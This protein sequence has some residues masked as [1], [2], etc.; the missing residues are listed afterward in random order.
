MQSNVYA[1]AISGSLRRQKSEL[2]RTEYHYLDSVLSD[3]KRGH[4]CDRSQTQSLVVLLH[5]GIFL[6]LPPLIPFPIV[7]FLFLGMPP[8]LL[9]S[10]NRRLAHMRM[11][12]QLSKLGE[13]V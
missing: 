10:H 13:R 6:S 7:T 1:L 9:E 11:N 3:A 8:F 2:R 5:G 4:R 12:K